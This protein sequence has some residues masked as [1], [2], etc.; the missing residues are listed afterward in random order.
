MK[1]FFIGLIGIILLVSYVV[2]LVVTFA[3][4]TVSKIMVWI[5]GLVQTGLE[6]LKLNIQY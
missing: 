3:V 4:T 5:T 1:K 6:K 2:L